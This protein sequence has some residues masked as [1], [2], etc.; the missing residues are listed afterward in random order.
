MYVLD[1]FS[2]QIITIAAN[3]SVTNRTELVQSLKSHAWVGGLS[4]TMNGL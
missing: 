3:L 2:A 1:T 4:N